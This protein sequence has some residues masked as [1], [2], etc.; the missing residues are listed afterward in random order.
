LNKQRKAE[1]K[2]SIVANS[3]GKTNELHDPENGYYVTH[4]NVGPKTKHGTS[5]SENIA[6]DKQRVRST[7]TATDASGKHFENDDGNKTPPKGSY[8]VTDVKRNSPLSRQ[9]EKHIKHAKYWSTGREEHELTPEEKAEG[10]E[11]HF[12]GNGEPTTPEK[13]HYG[14]MVFDGKRYE[15]QK[16][17]ILHPR[18]V[19]VGHN[20]DNSPHMIPTDSRFK[21]EEFL[22][23]NRF[24]T[25]NGKVAGYI[26]MTTPTESTSNLS[27]H[28]SFTHHVGEHNIDYAKRNKGEYEIDSPMHQVMA[29]GKEYAA[30]EPIQ[31][32]RKNKTVKKASGGTVEHLPQ[33]YNDD[34]NAF[35]ER[36]FLAQHH[37]ANR[38]GVEDETELP[39]SLL[40]RPK[41]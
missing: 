38:A 20:E 12:G 5:I 9:M 13:A 11:G 39:E 7:I 2:P 17:H 37:L 30:P 18:L 35:P 27:H 19:Q 32:V 26:L 15:Y 4:S 25:K 21:D 29:E 24:K 8:M 28:T 34:F 40:Q 31:I 14:H 1:G 41:D 22:P 6:R 10:E 23:K 3:Y 33:D 36:H 16:Q